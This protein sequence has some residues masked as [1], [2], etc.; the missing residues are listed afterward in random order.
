VQDIGTGLKPAKNYSN[1]SNKYD[2]AYPSF[3]LSA[4]V[5]NRASD[6]TAAVSGIKKLEQEKFEMNFGFQYNILKNGSIYLGL[7]NSLFSTG[8]SLRF[9]NMEITYAFSFDKIDLGY[10]NMISLTLVI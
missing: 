8:F 9:I 3:K 7:N 6:I 1:T 5:T 10:N 4:S 2:F